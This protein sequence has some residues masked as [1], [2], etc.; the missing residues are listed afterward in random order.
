MREILKNLLRP[1]SMNHQYDLDLI[2]EAI[3]NEL[4]KML[5]KNYI[6]KDDL[7]SI[8]QLEELISFFLSL[9]SSTSNCDNYTRAKVIAQAIHSRIVG[10]S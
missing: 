3:L 5:D 7:L 9:K 8:E 2:V 6:R 1:H 4:P 10:E